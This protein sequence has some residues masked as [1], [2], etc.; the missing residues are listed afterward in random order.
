MI[1][2]WVLAVRCKHGV[3]EEANDGEA[4]LEFKVGVTGW[5]EGDRSSWRTA[6]LGLTDIVLRTTLRHGGDLIFIPGD[7]WPEFTSKFGMVV[8][9]SKRRSAT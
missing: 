4:H 7:M 9:H 8:V 5:E 2:E 3:A 1:I 6:L